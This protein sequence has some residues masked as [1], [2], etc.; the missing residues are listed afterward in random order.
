M[1][2][3]DKNPSTIEV[4]LRNDWYSG[5]RLLRPQDNPHTLPK[6]A[7]EQLPSSALVKDG[8]DFVEVD[9]LRNIEEDSE[10]A[11]KKA[12]EAKV[13]VPATVK[14]SDLKI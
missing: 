6:R 2:K 7:L 14:K 11:E 10:I 1:T 4:Q 8:D 12:N 3:E 9:K 13:E 5:A